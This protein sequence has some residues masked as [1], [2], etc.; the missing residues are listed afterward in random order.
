MTNASQELTMQT[1]LITDLPSNRHGVGATPAKNPAADAAPSGISRE[2][3]NFVA[4]MEELTKATTSLT[5]D[6]LARANADL[7]ARVAAARAFVEEMPAALTDRVRNTVKAAGGY[8][9]EQPWQSIALTAAAGLLIGF[10]LG[11]RG[12]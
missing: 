6:D 11:R 8:V 1:E 9:H 10:L 4:D 3:R 7:Y 12:Q 5:G 2:F